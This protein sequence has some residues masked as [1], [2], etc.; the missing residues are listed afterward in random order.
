MPTSTI[1]NTRLGAADFLVTATLMPTV[2]FKISDSSELER[3]RTTTASGAGAWSLALERQSNITPTGSYWLIE[4]HIEDDGGHTILPISVGASNATLAASVI[5][6]VTNTGI[7][8]Y[9]TQ[10][11]ADARYALLGATSTVFTIS[12]KAAPYNAVGN[13]VADDY[14][15]IQDA[16]NAVSA[17]GGGIVFFPTGTYRILT[18]LQVPSNVVLMGVGASSKIFSEIPA[19]FA[20]SG[21]FSTA[22]N[23]V[24]NASNIVLR[25]FDIYSTNNAVA[26]D[27][28]FIT[29]AATGQTIDGVRVQNVNMYK[30][31]LR[32]W[33]CSANN[34]DGFIK[35]IELIGGRVYDMT[36][37]G[38]NV[39]FG[40]SGING[41]VCLETLF[42]NIG[43][44][45]TDWAIYSVDSYNGRVKCLSKQGSGGG[46]VKLGQ[47][48]LT[49]SGHCTI[50][51]L[52]E[53]TA[54]GLG[55]YTES[56]VE[57]VTCRGVFYKARVSIA[58]G[59]DIDVSGIIDMGNAAGASDALQ[60]GDAAATNPPTRVQLHDLIGLAGTGT[61]CAM[62][63]GS[64]ISLDNI[65][66]AGFVDAY[67]FMPTAGT[68][69]RVTFGANIRGK[70]NTGRFI[71]V[72]KV[73]NIIGDSP[74]ICKTTSAVFGLNVGNDATNDEI[75][76]NLNL[77]TASNPAV[78][79][80]AGTDMHIIGV[81]QNAPVAAASLS[82]ASRRFV[83]MQVRGASPVSVLATGATPSLA[84]ESVSHYGGTDLILSS[85]DTTTITSMPDAQ[86][87]DL[88]SVINNSTGT[89]QFTN[90]AALLNTGGV[91]VVLAISDV[92]SYRCVADGVL[93]QV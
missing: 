46:G 9:L 12:V 86:L 54:M 6:P 81:S 53:N 25:D 70:D 73:T 42:E 44:S 33:R 20:A 38:I 76:L 82:N 90:G 56:G 71:D 48:V 14:G 29:E 80:E 59:H 13:G 78:R 77:E 10:A 92:I 66:T 5:E 35:N 11:T 18:T 47:S 61:F 16:I 74:I 7:V 65:E 52:C 2:G 40:P 62:Y 31:G 45:N 64:Y 88:I 17:L 89:K 19:T 27:C 4:E 3:V 41:W 21:I 1:S 28:A 39:G 26:T 69:D 32:G 79:L 37:T 34:V 36:Q 85:T 58:S 60:I 23:T 91:N 51:L 75:R 83:H 84:G 67:S 49:D 15:A 8:S 43:S 50:D 68:L 57:N 30:T 24:A 55:F 63:C 22:L 87:G 72:N 93:A